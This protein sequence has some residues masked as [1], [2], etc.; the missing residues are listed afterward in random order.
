MTNPLHELAE[1]FGVD[2]QYWDWRGE[3]RTVSDDTLR[4]V[5]AAMDVDP[6]APAARV[7]HQRLP[8]TVAVRA[9]IP[10]P[11]GVDGPVVVELEDGTRRDA[12]DEDGRPTVPGDLPIGYHRLV[13]GDQHAHLIV[14]P[15]LV[16][17]PAGLDERPGWGLATQL[18]SVRSR[19]SWGVGDL[20]D[21]R[22]LARWAAGEHGAD[23]VLVNP[24]HAGEVVAPLDPSPYLPTSRRFA[25]PIYLRIEDIA[26]FA[27]LQPQ[28]QADIAR[29]G[30]CVR[31]T[32]GDRIERD[33]PW[34][35]KLAALQALR[36]I[37]TPSPSRAAAFAAYRAEQGRQLERFA[38]W[39]VLCELHGKDWRTW[40]CE[41]RDPGTPE[42]AAFA[43]E[44]AERVEFFSWI[45]WQLELQ[46]RAV[47]HDALEAGMR[48]GIIHDVAVGVSPS[49]ADA[50]ANQ[51]AM[52]TTVTVG[53]PP[54]A[55]SQLGQ[56]WQQPPWRP[57]RLAAEG[58]RAFREMFAAAL[59]H[60]GGLRVDHVIGLFRLWWI[61][62]GREAL[63]GTYVHYDHDAAARRARHRGTAGRRRGGRRGSGQ[64]RTVRPTTT[65]VSAA[66]WAPRSS[67]SRTTAPL[68]SRCPPSAGASCASPR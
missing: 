31:A 61:P 7:E 48:V 3:H 34:A 21:L 47:Q 9:G 43:A 35:A 36:E 15:E 46:L 65:C 67:G 14:S 12:P 55:Y 1:A 68:A 38:T 23:F 42:V 60:C 2:T 54:D 63:E 40:P 6:D 17:L 57:D 58:Y 30:D 16:T 66:S 22:T 19:E 33:Q 56:D 44:Q 45:Q 13:A 37:A 39:C 49:G 25:N 59:A 8:P 62:Q 10:V 64:R 18:Y 24:V 5:L 52:A 51:D 20:G 50:W 27:T 32:M 53:A 26:E 11:L 28:Q 4:A 41:L 29:Y